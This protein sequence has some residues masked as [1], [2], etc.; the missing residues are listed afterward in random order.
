[1]QGGE[2]REKRILELCP[3]VLDLLCCRRLCIIDLLLGTVPFQIDIRQCLRS[4]AGPL[5]APAD[6]LSVSL[7]VSLSELPGAVFSLLVIGRL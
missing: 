1:M 4:I 2:D 6:E 7:A 3:L 5:H